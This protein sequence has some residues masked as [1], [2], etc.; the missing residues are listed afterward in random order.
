MF[1]F[2]FTSLQNLFSPLYDTTTVQTTAT[3]AFHY[4]DLCSFI[5]DSFRLFPYLTL[6]LFFRLLIT[7]SST[8]SPSHLFLPTV[9]L[10][11]DHIT[12]ITMAHSGGHHL[13]FCCLFL[14]GPSRVLLSLSL[15]G[16]VWLAGGQDCGRAGPRPIRDMVAGG[17]AAL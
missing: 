17:E 15:P 6:L 12:F 3:Y 9:C 16:L 14:I 11:F 8:A 2:A 4:L 5:C 13:F 7:P 1:L 10:L